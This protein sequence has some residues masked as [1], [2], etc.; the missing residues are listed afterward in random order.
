MNSG[1]GGLGVS[2]FHTSSAVYHG[3]A[4]IQPRQLGLNLV[5]LA[6]LLL[7]GL[8]GAIILVTQKVLG[9]AAQRHEDH[10]PAKRHAEHGEAQ[11]DEDPCA[12]FRLRV[13]RGG[14]LEACVGVRFLVFQLQEGSGLVGVIKVEGVLVR[15]NCGVQFSVVIVLPALER[16]YVIISRLVI[17]EC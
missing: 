17:P 2:R 13:V 6:A 7:D 12:G 11:Q 10:C 3:S 8:G 4:S 15:Y 1:D 14:I 9:K 16:S 5:D